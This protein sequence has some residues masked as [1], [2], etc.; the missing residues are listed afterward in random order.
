VSLRFWARP[1]L[2]AVCALFAAYAGLSHY[3]NTGR[4]GQVLG[5]ALASGPPVAVALTLLWRSRRPMMALFAAL[6]GAALLYDGWPLLKKN[7][8][9]VYLLQDCGMYGLLSFGFGRSLRAGDTPLCTRLADKLH[10]PLSAGELHYTRQVT[11]AWAL[12]FAVITTAI[13]VLFVSA[14]RAIWSM[15]VNFATL[16]LVATMFAAEY[17]VRCRVLPDTDRRGILATVRVFLA[18]R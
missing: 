15:F 6:A 12:F 14:P 2:A 1:S 8:S 16:P 13:F 9:M 10:G 3:C 5:A 7:F 11:L 17:A 4:G 18:S